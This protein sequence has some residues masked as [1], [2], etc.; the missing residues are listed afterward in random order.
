M[1][2]VRTGDADEGDRGVRELALVGVVALPAIVAR[3]NAA[4]SG[5]RLLLLAAVRRIP[6]AAIL[7]EQARKDKSAAIRAWVAGPPKRAPDDLRLLAARYLD[8]LALAE[9]KRRVEADEDLAGLEPGV[10]RP[11]KDFKTVRKRMRDRR[12]ADAVQ[13]ERNRAALRF[14]HAGGRAL[15]EGRLRP[16]LS[17]P[18]FVAYLALLREENS[19]FYYALTALVSVGPPLAPV[20]EPLLTRENHDPRKILRLLFAV[21][22]DGGRGL[23]AGFAAM[24]TDAQ[25]A[26]V[27][28]APRVFEGEEL[29]SRLES[30]AV[31][32][33]GDVRAVA[34]D[35]LLRLDAPAGRAIASGLLDATRYG[36]VEFRRAAR[37]LARA[38]PPYDLL[39]QYAEVTVPDDGSEMAAQLR[40]LRRACI[41]ALRTVRTVALAERF[42]KAESR[43]L[44]TLGI[45]LLDDPEAL[46]AH[47][48]VEPDRGLA[49]AAGLRG[50]E[51]GAEPRAIVELLRRGGG[52]LP[53]Q[54]FMVLRRL[55]AVDLLVELAQDEDESVSRQALQQIGHLAQLDIKYEATLLGLHD[56]ADEA[57][58]VTT[59]RA[60]LPLGSDEVRRRF[61]Q[62]GEDGLK[63][64][65][66]RAQLDEPV[67]FTLP[68]VPHLAD[69]T[70]V[71]LYWLQ[72]A[73][74]ALQSV[75]PGFYHALFKAWDRVV[76]AA[77]GE[78][79]VDV[80]PAEGRS[81][82]LSARLLLA[83]I[84]SGEMKD[85]V[86]M[87][88]IFK[89]AARLADGESFTALLP[90]LREQAAAEHA[91]PE[92]TPPAPS[93]YRNVVLRGG[94][95]AMAYAQV[96][97]GLASLCDFLLDPGLQPASIDGPE[98]SWVPYWSLNALRHYAPD[99]VHAALFGALKRAE[100]DSRL[101][102]LHPDH[103]FQLVR[104]GRTSRDRGRRLNEV[105]LLLCWVLERLPW[106]GEV[107]YE[108]MAALGG[109]RRY[110]QAAAVA[111][112]D[113]AQKRSRFFRVEDGFWTPAR[114]EARGR[115]YDVL[116]S[117]EATELRPVFASVGDDPFLLNWLAWNALFTLSDV[118]L[119]ADAADLAVRN[120]AALYHQYRNT[121]AAVRN[122]QE[123]PHD[124]LA[125]LDSLRTLPVK[126]R[127]TSGWYLIFQARAH[128]KLDDE[129]SARQDLEA[130]LTMDRRILPYARGLPEFQRFADLFKQVEEEFRDRLFAR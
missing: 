18:I 100:A 15:R 57:R 73:A 125:L 56:K 12:L 46:V 79:T 101:S 115:I 130:A 26:M 77:P 10:G 120:T 123:R 121:L 14:A 65:A 38:G 71:R 7:L 99:K 112:T 8:L 27:T 35:A 122:A 119:A 29:V 59:L 39:T 13:N 43:Q 9:E 82:A 78:E 60:L 107:L 25:R 96:E 102:A 70:P 23:Y 31:S 66:G 34:L 75:E 83:E 52:H 126:R 124:A 76:P 50:L 114:M 110:E 84:A 98:Q 1:G 69:I 36:I 105:V 45:D 127:A 41:G 6:E 44:R 55:G 20:L 2:L 61:E 88:G 106:E 58:Q 4:E 40:M 111:R 86:L 16:G 85:P 117:G 89:A 93:S 113:A 48:R 42:L 24:R 51:L 47:A 108:K 129:K 72:R 32:E 19:S 63:V 87:L 64:V 103:L 68:L 28:L 33:E 5:E 49:V 62:A 81:E 67:P 37:L 22:H 97:A 11:A 30:A 91:G 104:W 118:A 116:A 21:R 128:L 74:D 80:D 54:L 94:I 17:D 92:R 95:N 109:M 3:L 53:R 90:L